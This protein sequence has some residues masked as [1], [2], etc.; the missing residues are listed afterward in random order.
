MAKDPKTPVPEAE[1]AKLLEMQS[2]RK[3]SNLFLE[4]LRQGT[5]SVQQSIQDALKDHAGL[6]IID[7]E[8]EEDMLQIAEI[9]KLYGDRF[10][11]VGSAGLAEHLPV[12]VRPVNGNTYEPAQSDSKPVMLVAG[13]I[14]K[15][16]REQVEVVNE[17]NG[18]KAVELDPIVLLTSSELAKQ[19]MHRCSRLLLDALN[20]GR[21]V[22]FHTGSS[23][24]QVS[25]AKQLGAAS[26]LALSDVSNRIAEALG[27]VTAEVLSK[28]E[29]RGLVLTG[30]DTAKAVCRHLGVHGIKLL[31]EI[32]PGIPLGQLLG[33]NSLLA[34]TKA[35]A[36]GNK[37]SL[38]H[39][40][41]LLKGGG[42]HE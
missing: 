13:S 32:E 22:S 8:S 3:V 36:F 11:W 7:A 25:A 17:D 15:V 37:Q 27:K 12:G 1:I 2:K 33:A 18:V 35:G 9:M 23:P 20:Q 4:T 5:E 31:K 26:G 24:E 14:S 39:A 21:D 30:G 41:K 34:V 38:S 16:T 19:E 29:L 6:I 42:D 40:M 10:L 28:Q